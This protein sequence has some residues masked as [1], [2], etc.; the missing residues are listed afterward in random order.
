VLNLIGK[1]NGLRARGASEAERRFDANPVNLI[2]GN[3]SVGK[4]QLLRPRTRGRPV[5][6]EALG[7]VFWR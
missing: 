5:T 4:Q 6:A 7:L 2:L 1:L 3:A